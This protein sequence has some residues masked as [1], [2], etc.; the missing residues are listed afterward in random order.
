[1]CVRPDKH[2]ELWKQQGVDAQVGSHPPT[3]TLPVCG[4]IM[5]TLLFLSNFRRIAFNCSQAVLLRCFRAFGFQHPGLNDSFTISIW[6]IIM[7]VF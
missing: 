4:D 7:I 6:I 5:G 1:V 2:E 3:K